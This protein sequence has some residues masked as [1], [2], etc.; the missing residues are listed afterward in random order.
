MDNLNRDV[1]MTLKDFANTEATLLLI[2]FETMALHCF[3]M[4]CIQ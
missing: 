3:T 4:G 2:I 1:M